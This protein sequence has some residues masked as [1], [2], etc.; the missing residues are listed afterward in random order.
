[1][2]AKWDNVG[3]FPTSIIGALEANEALLVLD[4]NSNFQSCMQAHISKCKPEIRYFLSSL[5]DKTITAT[6]DPA[7]TFGNAMEKISPK[8]ASPM[9]NR[10]TEAMQAVPEATT[11]ATVQRVRG[12]ASRAAPIVDT[13]IVATPQRTTATEVDEEDTGATYKSLKDKTNLMA[14]AGPVTMFLESILA[15]QS[16][17]FTARFLRTGN[18]KHPIYA[19]IENCQIRLFRT[20]MEETFNAVFPIE[21]RIK[22]RLEKLTS[23]EF[24][25]STDDL[26]VLREKIVET[27]KDIEDIGDNSDGSSSHYKMIACKSITEYFNKTLFHMSPFHMTYVSSFL[28]KPVKLESIA[29]ALLDAD[30]QLRQTNPDV[31]PPRPAP[32]RANAAREEKKRDR[33]PVENPCPACM[34]MFGYP[35]PHSIDKCYLNP[36]NIK[37]HKDWYDNKVATWTKRNKGKQFPTYNYGT[38]PSVSK[39]PRSEALKSERGM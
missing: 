25:D 4:M 13:P 34:T 27:V 1:M 33:K 22:L 30:T 19:A 36:A 26:L 38:A 21:E 12:R 16:R 17:Q 24:N 9:Q 15:K 10:F 35:S 32:V 3:S 5:A 8:K 18:D 28:V 37:D 6:E 39:R 7:A 14:I 11:N 29:G 20:I 2:S 31:Y 23:F